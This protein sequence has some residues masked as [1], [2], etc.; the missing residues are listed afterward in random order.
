[1]LE[2]NFDWPTHL[3]KIT[4][5]EL[6]YQW[7]PFNDNYFSIKKRDDF[8]IPQISNSPITVHV[9]A[10]LTDSI[11][12]IQQ[13]S[14][15]DKYLPK[16]ICW[17]DVSSLSPKMAMKTIK[18]GL[19]NE[20]KCLRSDIS[21]N[22]QSV[23]VGNNEKINFENKTDLLIYHV[24]DPNSERYN[25]KNN[26]P[27]DGN[28]I[29]KLSCGDLTKL[30]ENFK[31]EHMEIDIPIQFNDEAL[32]KLSK[33]L[34]NQRTI[35][36]FDCSYATKSMERIENGENCIAFAASD[37]ALNYYPS[38]PCDIF[39][40]CLLTPAKVSLLR[41]A[42]KYKDNNV[43][44][45]SEIEIQTMIDLIN[46]SPEAIN[47]FNILENA[48]EAIA[49]RIAFLSL[50]DD[51]DLFFKLFRSDIITSKF[52]YNF[53]FAQRALKAISMEPKSFPPLPDTSNHP[54]WNLFDLHIDRALYS[55][56]ESLKPSPNRKLM[57]TYKDLLEENLKKLETWLIY[58]KEDRPIPNELS[59]LFL[60]LQ[61]PDYFPRAIKFCSS[62][63]NISDETSKQFLS[64]RSFPI[65]AMKLKDLDK[66]EPDII[67]SYSFVIVDSILICKDLRSFF[68]KDPKFWVNSIHT[69]D[70]QLLIG[71]LSCLLVFL[72]TSNV[73]KIYLKKSFIETLKTLENH[74]SSHVRCLS[75]LIL[76]ELK[77]LIQ[78][79]L[80]SIQKE[81]STTCRAS[82]IS[83]IITT[84][85]QV[86]I[87]DQL[88]YEL[89]YDLIL[90]LDD[91]NILVREE[92][93]IGISHILAREPNDF[94]NSIMKFFDDTINLNNSSPIL[95]LLGTS[96]RK[97]IYESSFRL[98]QIF[99]KFFS[100][101]TQ[102]MDKK[103]PE[104]MKSNLKYLCLS[105]MAAEKINNEPTSFF[106][107]IP[108]YCKNVNLLGIPAVSPSGLLACGDVEGRMI[109]QTYS[110]GQ[111]N[112]RIFDGFRPIS[113]I[114]KYSN[115]F[116]PIIEQKSP[117]ISY[118]TYI[119]DSRI[120]AISQQSQVV[121]LNSNI[122]EDSVCSFC[123]ACPFECNKSIADYNLHTHKLIHSTGIQSV[124]LF[125][126]LTQQ[127]ISDVVISSNVQATSIQWLN[128]Y[129]S[130]FYV[131]QDDIAIFDYR[132]KR[133]A[134]ILD[135]KD[136]TFIGG[137]ISSPLP[138]Y[139]VMG[140]YDGFVSIFDI[141]NMEIVDE[142]NYGRNIKLFDVHN[143]LP[144]AL[145]I[146]NGLV[147]FNYENGII[148]SD[149]QN[150]NSIPN[151]FA[152]HKSESTCAINYGNKITTIDIMY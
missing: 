4:S 3:S 81:S 33:K 140:S 94:I 23:S 122:N 53:L 110:S 84:I 5:N 31:N 144:F 89:F 138:Y 64:T 111:K 49:D 35:Y 152:L 105:Q 80:P 14:G 142:H 129:S 77:I 148:K 150:Y 130:L 59:F 149:M 57:F 21:V 137:N 93:I 65:L 36:I 63:I 120:L 103:D 32:R 30:R 147:S 113:H 87:D 101:L 128:P 60:I 145:A 121:V 143:Q 107:S 11:E 99:S 40:S 16:F 56:K 34:K 58:P 78:V 70:K 43:G 7:L 27:F 124:S 123:A 55:L 8:K 62:F 127:R 88:N 22:F 126:L 41:Q 24:L 10:K 112:M 75:N 61:E 134:I 1:M 132:M 102:K 86:P 37:N 79:P 71:S 38:L 73:S 97:I 104:P 96:L 98:R 115:K 26:R 54:L 76:S 85:D 151:S 25:K 136:T 39:T 28:S 109:Y 83:R 106:G 114:T 131:A 51:Q 47:I 48:L 72:D 20:Y 29:S 46:D 19:E 133:P 82:I 100:F 146:S 135:T 139:L 90:A 119:D 118:I 18:S 15:S 117:S 42:Q 9:I 69:T 91:L 95:P 67:A 66:Y 116:L 125:D 2:E 68:P 52:F 141:R 44:L 92:A 45:L 12:N 108:L 74:Q 13:S 17:N 50:S 6:D